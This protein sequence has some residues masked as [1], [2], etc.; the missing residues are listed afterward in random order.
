MLVRPPVPHDADG[1]NREED[2]EGLPDVPVMLGTLQLILNDLVGLP[3][4]LEALAGHLAHHP[5]REAG[6]RERLAAQDLLGKPQLAANLTDLILE[7]VAERLD[8]L[9]A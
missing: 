5:D 7:Q 1:L 9:E 4:H 8:E 6:A 2:G 3:E